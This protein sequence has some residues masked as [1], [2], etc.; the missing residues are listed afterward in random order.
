MRPDDRSY[1]TL[2]QWAA[3]RAD[4]RIVC[5]CGRTINLPSEQILKRFRRDGDVPSSFVRLRCRRCGRRGH[6]TVTSVPILRR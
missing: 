3:D 5:A 6:A 1:N 2:S 4:M